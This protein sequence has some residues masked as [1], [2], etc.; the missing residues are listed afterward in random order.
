MMICDGGGIVKENKI[1]VAM[2][3]NH[4]GITGIGTVMMNYCKALDK[5][6]YDL[7]ILA[8]QPISEKYAKECKEYGIH[9]IALPSRHG[10]SLKHYSALWKAL[11]AGHYDIVHVHGSSSMMAIELTIARL[12]GVKVRIAHSHNS[13]CPNYKVHK[14]LNP[15]FRKIYS[16]ALACGKLAGDWLFGENNFEILPNGFH[17]ENFAFSSEDRA[18]IR[19]ELGVDDQL[20]IGHI[21]R[22]NEQK[23][24]EYLLKIFEKAAAVRN[25]AA[26]LIVGTGPDEEK[27]KERIQKHP[28]KE[29]IIFYGETDNPTAFYSAMDVFVFPSRYEGLPVVLLEAQISGLPCVVSDRVTKE[30]DLGDINWQSID[31]DP[32]LW[33]DAILAVKMR[34]AEERLEYKEEHIEEIQKYDIT[35]T[36][37]QLEKIYSDLMEK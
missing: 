34:T 11:K 5:D 2:V 21:G 26:L 14:V 15:Y 1:K 35:Q 30:V 25:D 37:K 9:L 19:N 33:A 29:R 16:K 10:E 27:I 4:F 13:T 18:A 23:N 31:G 12:A 7:T 24:Q 6:K 36:V 32:Q 28:Y 8:G 22:V 20:L 3:T 17:T